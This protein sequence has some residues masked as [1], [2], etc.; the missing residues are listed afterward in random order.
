VVTP[1]GEI[2]LGTLVVAGVSL[3]VAFVMGYM[4]ERS[5]NLRERRRVAR[6]LRGDW[7]PAFEREFNEYA[8]SHRSGAWDRGPDR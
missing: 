2:V 6:S 4:L 3:A 7:W 5:L 8:A 1:V